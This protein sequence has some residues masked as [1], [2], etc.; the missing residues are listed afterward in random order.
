MVLHGEARE[1]G[2]LHG[3]TSL[4]LATLPVKPLENKKKVSAI[5]LNLVLTKVNLVPG[6]PP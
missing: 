6:P 2:T 3:L 4:K 1:G 5:F